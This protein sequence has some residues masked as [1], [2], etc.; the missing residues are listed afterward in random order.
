[1]FYLT[2]T[3]CR[4]EKISVA[5][6]SLPRRSPILQEQLQL[7]DELM[8][9]ES[10]KRKGKAVAFQIQNPLSEQVQNEIKS[11]T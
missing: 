2:S 11:I 5:D 7:Q 4:D 3:F 10:R 6:I 8:T 1:M 9:E